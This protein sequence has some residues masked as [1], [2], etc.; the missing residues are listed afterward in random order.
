MNLDMIDFWQKKRKKVEGF[1]LEVALI[2]TFL[3]IGR[4]RRYE[5]TIRLFI[6]ESLF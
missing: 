6:W 2:P 5:T 3:K 4:V 1:G